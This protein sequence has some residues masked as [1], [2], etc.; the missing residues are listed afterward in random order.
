MAY[1][2]NAED[3][4]QLAWLGSSTLSLLL[5][6]SQTSGQLMA[7]S[8]VLGRGDAAPLHVHTR[9][10]EVF[11]LLEGSASV[12]VRRPAV[13]GRPWRRRVPASRRPAHLPDHL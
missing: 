12:L 13:R 2:A 4:Q 6:A 10:D 1:V 5:D 3:H 9:E 11:V 7:M 8:S